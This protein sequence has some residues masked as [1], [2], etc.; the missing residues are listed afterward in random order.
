MSKD[1]RSVPWPSNSHQPQPQPPV[2]AAKEVLHILE[3]A[4]AGSHDTDMTAG[5]AR[6]DSSGSDMG[7]VTWACGM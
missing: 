3:D 1:T 2:A 7:S 4:P 6:P 5:T